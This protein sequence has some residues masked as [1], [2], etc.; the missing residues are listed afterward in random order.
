LRRLYYRQNRFFEQHGRYADRLS[1]LR[2]DELS[3]EGIDFQPRLETT[4]SLY[5]ITAPGRD[6]ILLH[7]RQDGRAWTTPTRSGAVP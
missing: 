7:I 1:L 5:E 2:A 6:S 4:E 3:V